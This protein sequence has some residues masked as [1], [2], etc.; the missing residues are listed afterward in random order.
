VTDWPALAE[1]LTRVLAALPDRGVLQVVESARPDEGRYVQAERRAGALRVEASGQ[2]P[3]AGEDLPIHADRLAAAGWSAADD[4][5]SFNW[6]LTLDL[7]GSVDPT[8]YR[9]VAGRAVAALRDGF[10]IGSPGELA[11]RAWRDGT[12]EQLVYADLGL[13]AVEVRYYAWL[14]LPGD[15]L[16]KP[17]ALL[18]RLRVGPRVV[19][20]AY[21]RDL[22]WSP[23]DTLG[24]VERNELAGRAEPISRSAA[25][26]II[27]RRRER[28][29]A[30][31]AAPPP[32]GQPVAGGPPAAGLR[33]ATAPTGQ[34]DAAGDLVLPARLDEAERGWVVM[35]L[36]Q[37][38]VLAAAFGFDPDPF[39]PDRPEVVPI[40]IHTDGEWVWSEAL[41]YYAEQYGFAPEPDLL[42][43]IRS[44]G[45][46]APDLPEE[47]L[48]RLARQVRGEPG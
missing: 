17:T 10:D 39:R 29:R 32:A 33:E 47:T 43:H 48:N 42:Q 40:N 1:T 25:V 31:A 26:G 24:E 38:P 19:D 6:W 27:Q 11:Y 16:D 2:A 14:S 20:Q 15:T 22:R 7:T 28:A 30:T 37:A 13:P 46:R 8:A 5:H 36:R 44:R 4:P 45:Y 34:R 35:Y 23:S 41:A 3:L 21:T 18:R 12:L 9:E